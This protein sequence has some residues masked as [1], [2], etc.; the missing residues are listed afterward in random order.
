MMSKWIHIMLVIGV[1][2]LLVTGCAGGDDT[3]EVNLGQE[4]SL[5][6]GE[7]ASIS[8]EDLEI[9]FL[10]VL[11][12][13]RCPRDATCVWEGRVRCLVEITDGGS[14]EQKELVAPGLTDEYSVETYG[15]YQI[16]FRVEPYPEVDRQIPEGEYRLLLIIG[17]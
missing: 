2:A 5:A 9:E 15:D 17:K 16:T 14:P 8:G 10:D 13:S 3:V 1:L 11:E 7:R 4:F 6:I 12:D